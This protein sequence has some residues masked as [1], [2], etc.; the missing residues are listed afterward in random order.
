VSLPK[1]KTDIHRAR[2]AL[3]RILAQRGIDAAELNA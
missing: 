2:A 1:V 3:A